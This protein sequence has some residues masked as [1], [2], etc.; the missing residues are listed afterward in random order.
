MKLSTWYRFEMK[1]KTENGNAILII[2]WVEGIPYSIDHLV[3]SLITGGHSGLG[4]CTMSL[5]DWPEQKLTR[6]PIML[7][8]IS[9]KH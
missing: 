9:S 7:L 6:K 4:H 8:E 5:M 2:A 1:Y 3:C